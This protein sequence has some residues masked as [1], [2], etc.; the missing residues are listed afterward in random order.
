MWILR[1]DLSLYIV[2]TSR[3]FHLSAPVELSSKSPRVVNPVVVVLLLLL[4]H[5]VGQR[6]LLG[7]PYM[8][9]FVGGIPWVLFVYPFYVS[10]CNIYLEKKEIVIN[11]RWRWLRFC[12]FMMAVVRTHADAS[13]KFKMVL[14]DD[15]TEFKIYNSR[16]RVPSLKFNV[17]TAKYIL[18]T[19]YFSCNFSSTSLFNDFDS[20]D[21]N[22]QMLR[23]L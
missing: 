8:S 18:H 22:F 20:T 10:R 19:L 11:S 16:W 23:Y 21:A 14:V 2:S 7:Y 3:F 17:V 6:N 9:R 12:K 13:R 15:S 4:K 1:A 5:L